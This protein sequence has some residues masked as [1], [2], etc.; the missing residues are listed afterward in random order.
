MSNLPIKNT[1]NIN[2]C[3][4]RSL[5]NSAWDFLNRIH[6]GRGWSFPALYSRFFRC[7][8][9][10]FPVTIFFPTLHDVQNQESPAGINTVALLGQAS[11]R[12]VVFYSS[13]LG[14]SPQVDAASCWSLP[15]AQGLSSDPAWQRSV[16]I[17][18]LHQIPPCQSILQI[19]PSS[20]VCHSSYKLAPYIP[21]S[22]WQIIERIYNI[23]D[24]LM[25]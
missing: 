5:M 20:L 3:V 18:A 21:L 9:S 10:I 14:L 2:V 4:L 25:C 17:S 23:K 22:S 15:R 7:H 6:G 8:H 24:I 11:S 12:R 1:E 19:G 13:Q 16:V